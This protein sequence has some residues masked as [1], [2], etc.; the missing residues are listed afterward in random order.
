[1]TIAVIYANGTVKDDWNS[2]PKHN[3][4]FIVTKNYF[5]EGGDFYYLDESGTPMHSNSPY[6]LLNL[7]PLKHHVKFG[8][9]VS[10]EEF[11]AARKIA[12][13]IQSEMRCQ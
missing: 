13:A 3:I 11:S 6:S 8:V 12:L 2:S 9:T 10:N 4:L 7:F 5:C 1:M